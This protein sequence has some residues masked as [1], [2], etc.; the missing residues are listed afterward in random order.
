MKCRNN[1]MYKKM[2][3]LS[4]HI[5]YYYKSDFVPLDSDH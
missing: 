3:S 4:I 5:S 2:E 1:V